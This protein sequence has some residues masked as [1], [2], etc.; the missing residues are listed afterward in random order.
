MG[1]GL[2]QKDTQAATAFTT[3]VQGSSTATVNQTVSLSV[4]A[5]D[6]GSSVSGGILDVE[7]FNASNQRVLQQFFSNQNFV[8]GQTDRQSISWTP[9]SVGTYTVKVG[10]FA[11]NWSSMLSWDNSALQVSV[12][13]APAPSP[14]PTSSNTSGSASASTPGFTATGSTNPASLAVGQASALAANI[15]NAGASVASNAIVMLEV[16]DATGKNVFQQLFNGQNLSPGQT[17]GYSATWK[18]SIAGKYTMNVGVFAANW[19]SLLGWVS[20][21]G[22]MTVGAQTAQAATIAPITAAVTTN[23]SGNFYV[24]PNSSAAL[25]A[26]S[27]QSSDPTGASKLK[28][29]AGKPTGVWFGGW[30]SDVQADVNTVVSAAANQGTVPLLVAY[31]IPDR[32]CGGYSAG[33]ATNAGAYQGWIQMFA[34]GIGSRKAIV[35]LEPDGLANI[36]CLS[37]ADKSARFSMLTSAVNTLKSLGNTAVYLD[38]GNPNWIPAVTMAQRLNSAN[39]ARAD[40]FALNVSNFYTTSANEQY[41]NAVSALV[42]GKHYVIDT[43]RNG[44]GPDAN[45]TWCNP[46]GRAIG[47]FPSANTGNGLVNDFLW[48][49]PPGESDGSCN[50]GPAA[51]NFWPQ[52]AIGLV[53]NAGY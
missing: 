41:G 32:D 26:A 21:V 11:T 4:S 1:A 20:D 25:A 36:D 49:K 47:Q 40:G 29:L 42:G 37:S 8:S 45:Y 34:N 10:V 18:P 48:V 38:A 9:S 39:V 17:Q 13:S 3:T 19:S 28:L 6:T 22:Q 23:V 24:D 5:T 14:S 15:K 35:I 31:N 52:Y 2:S 51:G 44:N 43:S 27:M 33:G 46:S 12:V 30:N 50:G 53:E 7:V 16:A